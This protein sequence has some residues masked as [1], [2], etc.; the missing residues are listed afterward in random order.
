MTG[1]DTAV[2]RSL[3]GL[4]RM[5]AEALRTRGR[6]D[7]AEQALSRVAYTDDG[8]TIYVHI[9]ARPEWPRLR[10]G[11]AYVLAFADKRDLQCLRQYRDLL[12]DAWLQ[13]EDEIEDIIRWLDG[14]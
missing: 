14:R 10:P 9:F 11:Q 13:L 12:R 4:T 5:L 3:H 8:S 7:L 2:P 1:G 6:R